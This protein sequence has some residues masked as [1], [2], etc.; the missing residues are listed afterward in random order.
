MSKITFKVKTHSGEE[1][2]TGKLVAHPLFP[3]IEFVLHR[4]L[5][6]KEDSGW[7]LAHYASGYLV[8]SSIST[9]AAA[10]ESLTQHVA[11]NCK[12]LNQSQ[13]EV[14]KLMRGG[15]AQAE[16]INSREASTCA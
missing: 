1:E 7:S 13:E 15:M 9:Q 5:V 10:L 16:V 4:P 14:L 11:R 12:R 2:R 3:G 8:G 6:G